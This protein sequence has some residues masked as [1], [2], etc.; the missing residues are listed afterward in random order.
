LLRFKLSLD[1]ASRRIWF[2]P[3]AEN[4][5]QPFER[6]LVGLRVARVG[7]DLIK[8]LHVSDQS[9]AHAAGLVSGDLIV[10]IDDVRV[11]DWPNETPIDSWMYGPANATRTLTVV[12][13]R[14]VL[15]TLKRYY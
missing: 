10:A 3:L 13:G 2:A 1:Y 9:P 8:L 15:V 6:N 14:K 5:V 7:A 12:D 11:V 4:E